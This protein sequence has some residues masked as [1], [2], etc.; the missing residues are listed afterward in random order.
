MY[1][2]A[3]AILFVFLAFFMYTFFCDGFSKW[4]QSKLTQTA[5]T[6]I[7]LTN[8]SKQQLG[9]SLHVRWLLLLLLALLLFLVFIFILYL[10]LLELLILISL[11]YTIAYLGHNNACGILCKLFSLP[12][13][14]S[15]SYESSSCCCR[16]ICSFAVLNVLFLVCS[17]VV[18]V[19]EINFICKPVLFFIV[20]SFA[21]SFAS[22]TRLPT[23]MVFV[24][25]IFLNFSNDERERQWRKITNGK[26]LL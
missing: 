10:E 26:C 2:N 23:F 19:N 11:L 24:K 8:N 25:L 13:S 21:H 6:N 20:F 9:V 4:E 5:V 14:L 7:K 3:K 16:L 12:F 22:E 15:H 18:D 17:F 1:S